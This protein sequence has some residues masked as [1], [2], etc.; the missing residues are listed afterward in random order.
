MAAK[1]KYYNLI[2]VIHEEWCAANGYP[3][4][5]KPFFTSGKL[6]AASEPHPNDMLDAENSKR[7]VDGAKPQAKRDTT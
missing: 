6:Q 7:F 2:K 1:R 5:R 4:G 3:T